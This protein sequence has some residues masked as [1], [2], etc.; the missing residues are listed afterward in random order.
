M[1]KQDYELIWKPY[2]GR[3]V[4]A[5]FSGGEVVGR[6]NFPN[7]EGGF[8]DICPHLVSEAD[9]KRVYIEE[10]IPVRVSLNLVESGST[11]I[12]PVKENYLEQK[13]KF[14]NQ[15]FNANRELIGFSQ[16]QPAQ[17]HS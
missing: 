1:N 13:A 9:G 10:Q 3:I 7:I 6:F 14:I 11:F 4:I 8:V 16:N 12:R 5:N 2:I 15:R 17:N